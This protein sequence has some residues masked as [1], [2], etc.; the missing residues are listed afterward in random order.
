MSYLHDPGG[1]YSTMPTYSVTLNNYGYSQNYDYLA[2]TSMACPYVAGLAAFILSRNPNLNNNRV[3]AIIRDSARD[4]GVSGFDELYG[5]GRINAFQGIDLVPV[6]LG[7]E[8]VEGV[9]NF[10]NPFRP[11]KDDKVTISFPLDLE[12]TVKIYN[13]AGELVRKLDEEGSEVRPDKGEAYWD[14]KNEEGDKASSGLY[15]YLLKGD[16]GKA[17]GKITLIK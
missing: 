13:L 10:P 7:I 17:T 8:R 6:V 2:G 11:S 4:L 3:R 16:E 5:H 1:I 12:V 14:G 9:I 15:I